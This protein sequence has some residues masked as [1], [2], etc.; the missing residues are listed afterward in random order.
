MNTSG[1][2]SRIRRRNRARSRMQ[3]RQVREHLGEPHDRELFDVVPG[4]ATGGLHP[5]ARDARELGLRES[6]AQRLDERGTQRV[7]GCFA[8]HQCDAQ[9]RLRRI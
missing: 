5:R 2:Q 3:A 4:G 9:A 7:T 1:R 6:A 8:R